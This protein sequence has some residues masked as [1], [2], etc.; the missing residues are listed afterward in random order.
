MIISSWCKLKILKNGDISIKQSKRW[1]HINKI[2]CDRCELIF[3]E[4]DYHTKRCITKN[5]E[6]FC[7]KCRVQNNNDRIGELGA[8]ILKSFNKDEKIKYC[9]YAGKMSNIKSPNNKG[10]FSTERWDG[11]S[12]S[13]QKKQVHKANKALHDKLNNDENLKREHYLKIFKNSKIGFTSKGHNELHE[14]LKEYGFEQHVQISSLETDECNENL[15]MVIEFNGDLYHCNP[16]KWK[17]SDYNSVIKMYASDKWEK[18]RKRTFVLQNLGYSVFVV[19]EEDWALN[20]DEVKLKLIK[21]IKRNE[22]KE[23]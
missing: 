6:T 1:K 9:S 12:E 18:D 3:E 14:F 7:T 15:K 22:I 20:R 19:W 17:G 16:R 5:N 11:M 13:D 8:K 2:K 23:S 10:R 21:F 4:S